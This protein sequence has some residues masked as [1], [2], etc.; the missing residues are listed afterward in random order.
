MLGDVLLDDWEKYR[1]SRIDAG[2]RWITHVSAVET[3]RRAGGD[4]L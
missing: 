4:G 1:T 2:G 3:D